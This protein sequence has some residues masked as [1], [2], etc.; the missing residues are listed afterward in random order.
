VDEPT[1]VLI[2]GYATYAVIKFA[3]YSAYCGFLHRRRNDGRSAMASG[4]L[5]TVMGMVV[6]GILLAVLSRSNLDGNIY[7]YGVLIPTRF[8]EWRLLGILRFKKLTV[9]ENIGGIGVSFALDAAAMAIVVLVISSMG[10]LR[11]MIC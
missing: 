2:G 10:G 8:A 9:W 3:G 1:L 6:G 5:R 4:L 11:G 7:L